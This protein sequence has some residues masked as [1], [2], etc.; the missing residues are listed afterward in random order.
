[1]DARRREGA[2]QPVDYELVEA[3]GLRQV[4]EAMGT[5]VAQ[6]A[7]D[8]LA[9]DKLARALRD[10]RLTAVSSRCDPRAAMNIYPNVVVVGYERLAR[11]QPHPHAHGRAIGPMMARESLE[12]LGGGDNRSARV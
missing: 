8:C 4:L 10:E 3:L 11:V 1:V 12:P 5:E 7:R 2:W 6:C 9:G